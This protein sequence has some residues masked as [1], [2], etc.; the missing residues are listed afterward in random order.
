L[1]RVAALLG[2]A[3][4]AAQ[5]A[6]PGAL[7]PLGPAR[8]ELETRIERVVPAADGAAAAL[9]PL[10]AAPEPGDELVYTVTFVN[11]GGQAAA[12]IRITQPI[13]AAVRY[14]EGSAAA[15]RATVL[16][17][18]DGG[19]SFGPA[20]ELLVD[21]GRGRLR[22]ADPGAY[23]HVR[24]LLDGEIEPGARGFLRFRAIVR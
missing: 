14:V 1:L 13:P 12:G 23:T 22:P 8:L 2:T 11:A 20:E 6:T 5:V 3:G 21:D 15:P 10:A 4:A 9:V 19:R 7:V 16:F 18:I 24:G 17:S